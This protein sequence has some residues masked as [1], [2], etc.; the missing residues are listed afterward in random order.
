[1]TATMQ[2]LYPVSEGT[3]FDYDYYLAT[4]VPLVTEHMGDLIESHSFIK[5]VAGGPNVPPGFHG[6][7]TAKYKDMATLQAALSKSGPVSADVKNFTNVR[8]TVLIGEEL[9]SGA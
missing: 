7:F 5:G 4:H 9:S 6:I 1:M 3:T 2:V 8:P